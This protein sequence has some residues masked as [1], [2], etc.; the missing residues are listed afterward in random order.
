MREEQQ[1]QR[2][3][4]DYLA[5]VAPG[6]LVFAIPNSSR[7]APGGKAGNAVPGLLKGVWDLGL[8]LPTGVTAY[9]EV[10]TRRGKLSDDQIAFGADCEMRGTPHAVAVTIDDVRR[11]L[12]DWGVRTREVV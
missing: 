11:V 7:R 8:L 12:A 3:I 5:A 2:A 6:V 1:I 4:C 9:I 10:K